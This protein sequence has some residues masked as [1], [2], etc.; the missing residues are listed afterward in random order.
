MKGVDSDR[1]FI[2]NFSKGWVSIEWNVL[3]EKI[4]LSANI[5]YQFINKC[6]Q[7]GVE[8]MYEATLKGLGI[9]EDLY[10]NV[11]INFPSFMIN[12]MTRVLILNPVPM[13]WL[14]IFVAHYILG[15]F[16]KGESSVQV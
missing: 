16:R 3:K 1:Y 2:E 4:K 10:S 8:H 12:H 6:A 15:A 11:H 14:M 13:V 7:Q 5:L 9:M